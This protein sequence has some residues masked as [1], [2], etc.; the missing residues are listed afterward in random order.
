M[1]RFYK[2][3]LVIVF[4][5]FTWWGNTSVALAATGRDVGVRLYVYGVA[6]TEAPTIPLNLSATPVST[7]A[8]ILSW[9]SSTDNIGVAG[10]Q[11]FRDGS[12]I[13][14]STQT[15]YLDNGLQASTT[16]QYYLTAFDWSGNLSSSSVVVATTTLSAPITPTTT[17]TST[18]T[19]TGTIVGSIDRI[20]KFLTINISPA[21]FNKAG[22]V[23]IN[24]E[25]TKLSVIKIRYGLTPDFELGSVVDDRSGLRHSLSIND[26][27]L[28]R[29][30]YL[31]I[32]AQ[33]P[34]GIIIKEERVVRI[35]T[36]TYLDIL[37]EVDQFDYNLVGKQVILSWHLNANKIV[38]E[39]RL[40]RS[41]YF[42]PLRPDGGWLIYRGLEQDT[43][44]TYRG[45]QYYTIFVCDY[46]GKCSAGRWLR[47]PS[48]PRDQKIIKNNIKLV[49]ERNFVVSLD[50]YLVLEVDQ[51]EAGDDVKAL[52]VEID[53]SDNKTDYY[54]LA[55]N[56]QEKV[57]RSSRFTLSKV[58][59]Y[60]YRVIAYNLLDEPRVVS[61][62]EIRVLPESSVTRQERVLWWMIL[63]LIVVFTFLLHLWSH[64][65]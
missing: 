39:V 61:R 65:D 47:V 23:T 1:S 55:I 62:G 54:Q 25:T 14:T 31:Q 10:Y 19:T 24:L 12:F 56:N 46:A 4:C 64:K 22:Q 27:E 44:D 41:P 20:F 51:A 36:T 52:A 29:R 60:S 33:G 50:D 7:S 42:Y 58:G 9:S 53:L 34:A 59:S 18:P 40:V 38:K 49:P 35:P 5:L 6:D 43:V 32:L 45:I 48:L 26:L 21:I 17:P 28:G 2:T 13:A 8:V 63:L 3:I 37:P 16:Y 57:Y 11:I 30:Y 15:N